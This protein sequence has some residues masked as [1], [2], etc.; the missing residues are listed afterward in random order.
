MNIE[1]I[2]PITCAMYIKTVAFDS[3]LFRGNIIS[4][5]ATP[6]SKQSVA[7]NQILN[8][9]VFDLKLTAPFVFLLECWDH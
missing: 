2:I 7:G 1:Q 4:A 3:S 6:M 9:T 8:N 5:S